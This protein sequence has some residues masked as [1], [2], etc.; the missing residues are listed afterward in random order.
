MKVQ[1]FL[2]PPN[3]FEHEDVIFLY[4]LVDVATET[5]RLDLCIS[6]AIDLRIFNA[7]SRFWGGIVILM[8]AIE[9]CVLLF[10]TLLTDR[11][12]FL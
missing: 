12:C 2:G 7:S 5:A 6:S 3:F 1:V 8:V 10:V 11:R 4:V 9:S